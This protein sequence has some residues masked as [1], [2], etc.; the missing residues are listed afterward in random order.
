MTVLSSEWGAGEEELSIQCVK[1]HLRPM[2]AGC[3]QALDAWCYPL[4][5]LNHQGGGGA[6]D[7]PRCAG[8]G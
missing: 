1:L 5:R 4:Q 6:G 7:V 2:C 8:T 3:P